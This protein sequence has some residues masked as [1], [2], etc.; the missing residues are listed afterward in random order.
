MNQDNL[1][2]DYGITMLRAISFTYFRIEL[3]FN[4]LATE[5]LVIVKKLGH[6]LDLKAHILGISVPIVTLG[7][8]TH[9]HHSC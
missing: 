1:L 4:R 2:L 9:A 7:H 6:L 3:T 8:V 5:D